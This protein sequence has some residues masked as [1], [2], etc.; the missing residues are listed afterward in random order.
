MSY[1]LIVIGG[2][3]HGCGV[4]QAAAADGYTV[5]L[6]EK[7]NLAHG[8]SSRS[9]KLIHGGLRYLESYQFSLVRKSLK[10]R[11]LLLR[12]AP[13]LVK[14]VPFYIPIYRNTSR[15]PWQIRAG[16][17]LYAILAGWHKSALFRKLPRGEWSEL[18][19]LNTTGLQ[20]VYQ[21]WDAQTNDAKLTRAVMRSAENLEAELACPATFLGARKSGNSVH[22]E[23]EHDGKPAT[24]KCRALI[25]AAGPWVGRVNRLIDI[26]SPSF[27][28]DLVQGTHIV[29]NSE[30]ENGIYYTEAIQD[31][32][33]IFTMPWKRATLVGTTEKTYQGDPEKVAPTKQEISYLQE[34]TRHYFP[35][36]STDV[37][38]SFAGLRVL[39]ARTGSAFSRPRDTTLIADNPEKPSHISIYGGKLTGYRETAQ[40]VMAL[41]RRSLPAARPV[42]DTREL[43]LSPVA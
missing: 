8:T 3:I 16:L 34:N 21:Y 26:D 30:I 5:L 33:A 17:S 39:P 41:A 36:M 24:V 11:A 31:Q 23:F 37:K 20:A 40:E 38:S 1:D 29:V 10:E 14:L 15:R 13:E 12:N 22:V 32:R 28:V 2:G 4:A 18:D 6:L 27:P 43:W 9:S 25:N 42:A 19:G 7:S 35:D